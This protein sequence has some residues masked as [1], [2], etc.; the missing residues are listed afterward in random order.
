M[1]V[2][3]S[4]PI[5]VT[6]RA[7]ELR[8]ERPAFL[9]TL[10][11]STACVRELARLSEMLVEGASALPTSSLKDKPVVRQSPG[12]CIVQ[13]GPVAITV[14][15]LR[16]GFGSVEDGELMAIVWR[17]AVAPRGEH[18]PERA[19]ARR[20]PSTATALWEQ[21]LRPVASD[22]ASWMWEPTSG[23]CGSQSSR[24][25][26]ERCMERLRLAYAE[27]ATLQQEDV[28]TAG[29]AAAP[30]PGAATLT[31]VRRNAKN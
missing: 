13:L 12:R 16:P 2:T 8:F 5:P 25:L 29:T 23:E 14:T 1:T 15:W 7:S 3:A 11:G 24:T 6:D 18:H 26:A 31:R 9:A 19:P 20:A 27:H 28:A 10:R 30:M 17:G 4:D 22:E 21:T